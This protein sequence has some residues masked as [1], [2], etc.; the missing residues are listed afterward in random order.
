IS[1]TAEFTP[2]NVATK[3]ER[4]N[5]VFAVTLRVPNLD[6]RLKPGMPADV[7]FQ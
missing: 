7:V 3:E 5:L 1:E 6:G 2:R 4:A